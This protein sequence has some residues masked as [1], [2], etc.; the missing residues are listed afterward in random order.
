MIA[1]VRSPERR[2]VHGAHEQDPQTLC[3]Q[4]VAEIVTNEHGRAIPFITR[5]AAD[6]CPWCHHIVWHHGQQVS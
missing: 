6:R 2:Q 3:G 4:V 5:D 1:A